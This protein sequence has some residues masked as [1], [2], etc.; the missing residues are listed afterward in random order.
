MN[1]DEDFAL[2]VKKIKEFTTIDLNQ[3]KEAQMRRRLTTLRTKKGFST[4][5]A[6]YEAISKDKN[7][8][9]E[10]LDRMTINVSEFWRNANRW[11]ILEKKFIPEMLQ[12]NRKIKCWSAACSTGEEPYTLAMIIA[13]T[14]GG[15]Q[16]IQVSATDIDDGALEKARAGI[17]LDRS[18][19]DVPANYLKKY[20][21]Q[22]GIM[23]NI[24]SDLKAAVKFQKQNLLLDKFEINHD[25]IVCRNVMIYFTEEAK[26]LLYQK[27]AHALRPGGILF[28]GST[29]QIFTPGQYNLEPVDTF[30]YR[31]K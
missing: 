7:L 2:F 20:F 4:F 25:L 24:T 27:F 18:I 8:L 14:R 17:Y 12:Q 16:D 29:E 21:K 31:K 3:Y 1:D 26:H 5:V 28:V 23:Y 9:Y 13:E 6:F 11:E 19:R 10:F 15:L 22:N 30:F